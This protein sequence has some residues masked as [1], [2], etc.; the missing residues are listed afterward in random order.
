MIYKGNSQ[1]I[2]WLVR[3]GAGCA[4][5]EKSVAGIIPQA[6]LKSFIHLPDGEVSDIEAVG[7]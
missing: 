2:Q 1:Q 6:L 4:L 7:K 5:Q 3:M